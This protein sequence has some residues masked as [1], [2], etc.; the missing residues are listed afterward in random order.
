MEKTSLYFN[1]VAFFSGVNLCAPLRV[2]VFCAW[3]AH[4]CALKIIPCVCLH[5]ETASRGIWCSR[6]T[7]VKAYNPVLFS[8]KLR[9]YRADKRCSGF[10][11]SVRGRM[12]HCHESF[13]PI[14]VRIL[15][16]CVFLILFSVGITPFA[17]KC[18]DRGLSMLSRFRALKFALISIYFLILFEIHVIK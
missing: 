1:E 13:W 15:S 14:A 10:C 5:P 7:A 9:F 6:S 3:G 2:Q 8:T 11:N 4:S 16:P 17:L 18:S 12:S